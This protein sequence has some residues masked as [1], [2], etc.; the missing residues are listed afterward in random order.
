MRLCLPKPNREKL[1]TALRSRELSIERLYGLSS[2]DRAKVLGSYVG[3]DFANLVNAKFEQAMVSRQK[4]ALKGWIESATKAKDP[5]RRDMMKKVERIKEVLTPDEEAGFLND[6]AND[7]LGLNVTEEEAQNIMTLHTVA[8]DL[9]AKITPE[10]PRGS[11]ER[12][13]FGFAVDQFKQYVGNLKLEAEAMGIGERIKMK[14]WGKDLVDLAAVAKSMVATLDN[15][16]VGRQGI[17]V[18]FTNPTVWGKTVAS[19]LK[20]FGKAL[21]A[22][23]NGLFSGYDD[24][25]MSAIRADIYSRPNAMAGK[26]NA[27]KN[28]YGLNVLHEEAFPTSLPEKV[29]LL[30]RLFKASETAFGGSALRMRADLAD[31]VIAHAE[32]LEMDV[33]DETTASALG[34]LVSSLTG[35]GGLGKWEAVGKPI[36]AAFFSIKFLKSNLDTLTAHAFDA[37]M[38][39]EVRKMAIKNLLKIG[40]GI[41]AILVMADKL[42]PGSVGWDPRKGRFGKIRIGQNDIDVTGGMGGLVQFG[43]RIFSVH[44]GVPGSWTY[45]QGTGKW[46]NM[47]DAQYG[48]RTL[49]DYIEQFFEGKLSPAAG[50]LRD[51]AKGQNFEGQKP[52]PGTVLKGLTVPI[53]A[54]TIVQG[55][56]NNDDHMLTV[57]LMELF[58]FSTTGTT[59][60]GYGKK[61]QK[62]QGKVDQPTY[63]KALKTVT[64]N[65][66][67]RAQKLQNTSQWK[68][69]TTEERNKELDK[70][71]AE[72][73]DRIFNRYGI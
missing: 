19:S 52:T 70:I 16:F 39:P 43:S 33:M 15:S 48:E 22:K 18:L 68:R 34:S 26:Y 60:R 23:S 62:L 36:N 71:R 44:D 65:F 46:S 17:K 3:Q 40:A 50:A 49:L 73:S 20:D 53:S 2:A 24:A 9:G 12:M 21:F 7:K 5:I 14:N 27:A 54:D 6:L 69:W 28:G 41:S 38:T 72:E 29:P 45:S 4:N 10:M 63:A 59:M 57:A 13:A 11:E 25:A 51:I 61:W 67:A 30:G 66:N 37:Q 42:N 35:R 1:A 31:A 32:Q 58:G 64:A 8:N 55:L 47:T 56:Q